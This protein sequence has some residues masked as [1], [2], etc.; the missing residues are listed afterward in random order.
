MRANK[1][2]TK[3]IIIVNRCRRIVVGDAV[4]TKIEPITARLFNI[5]NN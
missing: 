3:N 4:C 5:T 1:I 2:Q